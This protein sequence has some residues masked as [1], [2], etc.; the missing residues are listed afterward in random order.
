VFDYFAVP[1]P[2]EC[3]I[4]LAIAVLL[5]GKGAVL[6]GSGRP[7][8]RDPIRRRW[9]L[10]RQSIVHRRLVDSARQKTPADTCLRRRIATSFAVLVVFATIVWYLLRGS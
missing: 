1:G 6:S 4:I 7:A 3:L 5:F 9:W 10:A 2:A 8:H